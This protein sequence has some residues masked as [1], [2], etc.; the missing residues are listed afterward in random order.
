MKNCFYLMEGS[1]GA[2]RYNATQQ[3]QQHLKV[4][5]VILINLVLADTEKHGYPAC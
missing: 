1:P 2:L 4:I 5:M 3:H